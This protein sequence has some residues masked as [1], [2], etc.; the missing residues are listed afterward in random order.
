MAVVLDP[1]D[2]DQFMKYAAEENL[3]AV[4]VAVVKAERRMTL[5]WRGKTIVDLSRDFIDTNGAHQE[6]DVEVEMPKEED[7]YFTEKAVGDV[8]TAW[9]E[10]LSDLNVCSQ[11]GLVEMVADDCLCSSI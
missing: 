2:V 10:T 5:K 8:K 7:N 6:T 1:K 3:E 4:E 9:M 11:K